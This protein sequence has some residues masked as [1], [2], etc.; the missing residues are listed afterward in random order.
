MRDLREALGAFIREQRKQANLPGRQLAEL[1]A[2]VGPRVSTAQDRLAAAGV[3]HDQ[4]A[5][6]RAALRLAGDVQLVGD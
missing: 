5:D 4:G 3:L 6:A 1:A 2:V